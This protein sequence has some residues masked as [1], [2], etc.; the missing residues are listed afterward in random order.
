MAAAA[1]A[2]SGPG[3]G[4]GSTLARTGSAALLGKGKDRESSIHFGCEPTKWESCASG[5]YCARGGPSQEDFA[6]IHENKKYLRATSWTLGANKDPP[7]LSTAKAAYKAPGVR[8]APASIE[9]KSNQS[10]WSLGFENEPNHYESVHQ[11]EISAPALIRP[12]SDTSLV[13]KETGMARATTILL[14]TDAGHFQSAARS[15]HIDFGFVEGADH[16][17]AAEK[18]KMMRKSNFTFGLGAGS[19]PNYVSEG[20]QQF[21]FH[22][23]PTWL[24]SQLVAQLPGGAP[25]KGEQ[26]THI[27]TGTDPREVQSE[28]QKQYGSADVLIEAAKNPRRLDDAMKADLRACHYYLGTDHDARASEASESF[29]ARGNRS[30]EQMAAE[31][32][33]LMEIRKDLRATH[34]TLGTD[35]TKDCISCGKEAFS[36]P[37]NK[38]SGGRDTPRDMLRPSDHKQAHFSLGVDNEELVS[39]RGTTMNHQDLQNGVAGVNYGQLAAMDEETKADLRRSHFYLSSGKNEKNR[40]SSQEAYVHHRAAAPYVIPEETKKELRKEHF[41][42]GTDVG[43]SRH[44]KSTQGE[45][46]VYHGRD[47]YTFDSEGARALTKLGRRSNYVL[48]NEDGPKRSV[49]Q[50]AYQWWNAP[51]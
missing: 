21:R 7:P 5:S 17:A 20:A 44:S 47:A 15:A 34:I 30:P 4:Q 3:Q 50:E 41:T 46:M 35:Q 12:N 27:L 24:K 26:K 18:T 49:A 16:G 13:A 42:Y 9:Q 37:K 8:G 45:A 10:N 36:N 40:S 6:S 51:A 11:V 31:F 1:P 33:N 2:N 25:K 38:K 23:D 22:G 48:G 43:L 28:H 14:G 29:A 39:L 32:H 19:E